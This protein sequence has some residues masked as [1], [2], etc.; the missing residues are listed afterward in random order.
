MEDKSLRPNRIPMENRAR[1]LRVRL[2]LMAS[3][4][5]SYVRNDSPR[6][7]AVAAGRAESG[8]EGLPIQSQNK[9]LLFPT[10]SSGFARK[11]GRRFLT[12]SSNR[13]PFPGS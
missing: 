12:I 10:L 7:A 2:E 3:L 6:F 5:S 1:L 4:L 13:P 9:N 8:T 11:R